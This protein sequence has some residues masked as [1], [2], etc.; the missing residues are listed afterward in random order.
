MKVILAAGGTA[1]HINPALAAAGGLRERIPDCEILFIGTEDKMES[2]LVPAAGFDFKSI[3]ISGFWRSMDL[4]SIRHNLSTARKLLTA[5][6]GAKRI[7]REFDPDVVVGFGGYVSGPVL[8][9]AARL[10]IPTAIHEQNALPGVTNKALAKKVDC[11]MLTSADAKNRMESKNEPVITGLPVRGEMLRA[12]REESRKKLGI[13]D[14]KIVVLSMGG[15]LGADT[16]NNA[17]VSLISDYIDDER[18]FFIHSTGSSGL[19]VKDKLLENGVDASKANNLDLREYIDDMDVCMPAADLVIC[20]AGA[21]S[22]AELEALSKASI[23]IPSPTV[24]ENHQYFNAL[25]LS[26][27]GAAELIEE[28]DLTS[29][30]LKDIFEKM[31][32]DETVLEQYGENANKLAVSD[33]REK[34]VDCILALIG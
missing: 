13:E 25:S 26:K 1:G 15:S 22:L 20:R 33:A 11:V 6:K 14:G 27:R 10:G 29:E 12:S 4:E 32:S 21:S 3:D 30:K 19:W 17:M 31:V 16:I 34:I 5:S 7:I 23:L 18:F 28:K 24:A 9:E 8:M 2:R